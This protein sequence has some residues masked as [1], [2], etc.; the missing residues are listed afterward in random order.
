MPVGLS[1]EVEDTNPVF[2]DKGSQSVPATVPATNHNNRVLRF[3]AR[4]DSG[5]AP[6]NPGPVAVVSDGAYMRRG[7]VN[8]TS[9]GPAAGITFNIGF[10]NSAAYCSWKEKKLHELDTL[11]VIDGL[12]L[13]IYDNDG[14]GSLL[15]YMHRLYT[16]AVPHD[17]TLAVFP[18]AIAREAITENDQEKVYWE[19]LNV[20]EAG[21]SSMRQPTKIN[22]IIDGTVTELTVPYGYCVTP[23]VRVWALL[24]Y[25]FNDLGA[26]LESNPF[27]T[28]PEL[29][30]LVVLN[31]TADAVCAGRLRYSELVPDCTVAEF[32]NALWVRFGLTFNVEYD[33]G[34]TR[35]YFL[36]D[37]L[38]AGSG[39][40]MLNFTTAPETINYE[41]AGYVKLSAKTSLEY[42]APAV[43]RF[44]DFTKGLDIH[45]VRLGSHVSQWTNTGTQS[46]PVWDG[47][48]RDDY[49]D[50]EEPDDRDLEPWDPD[51]VDQEWPEPDP[52]PDW[53]DR[54][55]YDD[56][57]YDRDYYSV[58]ARAAAADA[59]DEAESYL[60]REFITG[61]WYKLDAANNT[62]KASSSGFF[63][64]DPATPGLEPLDLS[65]DDECVPVMRVNTRGLGVGNTFND[66]CPLY[67]TGARHYHSYIVGSDAAESTGDTTPL[68]FVIAYTA[69]G[70]TFGRINP[71]SET[72]EAITMDD[73][74]RPALSLLFQFRDG[75]FAKYWA[76][77]DEILRHSCRSVEVPLRMDKI[78]YYNID[79]M[80]P[81]SFRGV[82]CLI[83]TAKFTLPAA[84][85]LSI[86]MKLR[87]LATQG[88][89]DIMAEQNVP[90]FA[91]AARRLTWV[92]KS[93]SYSES[94]LADPANRAAAVEKF[95]EDY[96]GLTLDNP[97]SWHFHPN[98]AIKVGMRRESGWEKDNALPR[99]TQAG[100]TTFRAYKALL[101]YE[102][103]LVYGESGTV[104][105]GQPQTLGQVSVLVPYYVKLEARWVAE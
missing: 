54:D 78:T 97:K 27:R 23:F 32:M 58:R 28:D 77:Y 29:A 25:I 55:D 43:D 68:A 6:N 20:P 9:A 66:F 85:A 93:E 71:E 62:V 72:G 60:A 65:S 104:I 80:L 100:Q 70:R 38:A 59:R 69:G 83:D 5:M 51:W 76:A 3:P 92:L 74:T 89:Y 102:I 88:S 48:V 91:V 67:L 19:M 63:N 21:G 44:E 40:E 12:S 18:V 4:V 10:D 39:I 99:P 95:L 34:I 61:T 37:I 16:S 53:D 82:R 45:G 46:H 14:A 30:G 81:V 31:N 105:G 33:R 103:H 35:L 22:R 26:P 96:D 41:A 11:P 86:D 24:D 36:K 13:G 57:D 49:W 64:W 94:M 17:D 42:A 90:D 52:E 101:T 2:N 47:D 84:G 50:R 98:G 56:R 79:K 8:V 15:E 87:A 1:V 75:L 7:L 73:G